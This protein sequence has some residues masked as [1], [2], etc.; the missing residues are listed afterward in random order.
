MFRRNSSAGYAP[1]RVVANRRNAGRDPG[2]L[3]PLPPLVTRTYGATKACR[4]RIPLATIEQAMPQRIAE[5]PSDPEQPIPAELPVLRR[6]HAIQKPSPSDPFILRLDDSSPSD[7]AES[8]PPSS[9]PPSHAAGNID[10]ITERTASAHGQHVSE[11]DE[12]V[13]I[14]LR[15]AKKRKYR[16]SRLEVL[17]SL[18]DDDTAMQTQAQILHSD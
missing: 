17:Q 12:A 1:R 5:L 14:A 10:G 8:I 13:L 6:R 2:M 18:A 15:Y 11:D 7:D 3:P 9:D 16:S 4:L